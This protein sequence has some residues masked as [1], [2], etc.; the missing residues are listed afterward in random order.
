M[1][2]AAQPPQVPVDQPHAAV[3]DQ[4][5]LEDAAHH[6]PAAVA[7]VARRNGCAFTIVSS[8]SSAAS[9]SS[10]TAPPVPYRARPSWTVAVRIAI[11]AI[12]RCA[13]RLAR[14]HRAAVEAARLALQAVDDLHRAALRRARD[15]AAREAR[16]E[17]V[18][19]PHVRP[20]ARR[21]P[22]TRGAS[23]SR[24]ARS[25]TAAVT[26]TRAGHRGRGRGRCAAGRRS[27]RSRRGPSRTAFSSAA[28]A[29]SSAGVA[30]RRRVPL[31]GRVSQ[32]SPSMRRNSSG[33]TDAIAAPPVSRYAEW[34]PGL[35]RHQPLE[36]REAVV[37]PRH[38]EHVREVDLEQL[39]ERDQAL[40]LVAQRGVLRRASRRSRATRGGTSAEV[41]AAR[42]RRRSRRT[43]ARARR[44]LGRAAPRCRLRGRSAA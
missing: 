35:G 6:Q 3:L 37:L 17:H 13:A 26:C 44:R 1:P 36:Q 34:S 7:F 32:R 4:H 25:R 15:R 28:S 31:I 19:M 21:P 10:V 41:A 12:R 14:E 42:A 40:H 38:V 23:R 8:A 30:P 20:H 27:S 39:A 2:L 29:A 16:D 11:D 22:T 5:R 24:S 9:E 18:G 33:E 43:A